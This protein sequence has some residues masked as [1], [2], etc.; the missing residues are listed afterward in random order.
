MLIRPWAPPGSLRRSGCRLLD[1]EDNASGVALPNLPPL[2]IIITNRAL[3]P[4]AIHSLRVK[5]AGD[6][7]P[8]YR[9]CKLRV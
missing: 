5:A 3:R 1:R 4:L 7:E 2:E 8:S 9:V 6:L